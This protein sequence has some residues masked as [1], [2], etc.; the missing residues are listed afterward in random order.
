MTCSGEMQSPLEAS[1]QELC[2]ARLVEEFA[3]MDENG[4]SNPSSDFLFWSTLEQTSAEVDS[5]FESCRNDP[6]GS[7]SV[8]VYYRDEAEVRDGFL[9]ALRAMGLAGVGHHSEPATPSAG[10]AKP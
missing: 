3:H 2:N 8:A 4:P 9:I 10:S 6:A 7:P 5:P 1:V